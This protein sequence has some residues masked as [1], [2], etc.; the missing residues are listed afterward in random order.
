MLTLPDD[1]KPAPTEGKDS[2]SAV[3]H[4]PTLRVTVDYGRYSDPIEDRPGATLRRE[5]IEVD[6]RTAALVTYRDPDPSNELH[7][8]VGMHIPDV[9]DGRTKLTVLTASASEQDAADA[10]R[11][12]E[13]V[14]VSPQRGDVVE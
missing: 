4:R 6:G 3:Y 7:Q 1:L 11:I 14:R 13:S 9:G 10:R 2:L 8:V 5:A 12:I